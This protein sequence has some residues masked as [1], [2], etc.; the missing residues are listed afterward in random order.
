MVKRIDLEWA[1]DCILT[2]M[3]TNEDY[4]VYIDCLKN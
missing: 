4:I 3:E 2:R 1:A